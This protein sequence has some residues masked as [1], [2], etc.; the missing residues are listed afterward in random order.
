VPE[1]PG[2]FVTVLEEVRVG[3]NITAARRLNPE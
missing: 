2:D 3:M 1:S